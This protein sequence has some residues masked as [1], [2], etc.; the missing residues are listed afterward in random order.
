MSHR[1]V[2]T[3]KSKHVCMH[4]CD[5]DSIGEPPGQCFHPHENVRCDWAEVS[6]KIATEP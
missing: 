6:K 4:A 1:V 3:K 5:I 2:A